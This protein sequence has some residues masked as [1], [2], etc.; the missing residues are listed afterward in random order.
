MEGGKGL[1]RMGETERKKEK[2]PPTIK[3][4]AGD[5]VAVQLKSEAPPSPDPGPSERLSKVQA[6]T[7]PPKLKTAPTGYLSVPSST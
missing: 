3:V 7:Y 2:I 6:P 1:V 4:G 5:E